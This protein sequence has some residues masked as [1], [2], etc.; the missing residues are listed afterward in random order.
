MLTHL[1]LKDFAIVDAV[2]LELG[3]GLTALTGETGAGKSI[4]VDAVMAVIG[5]RAGPDVVRHGSERA[6]ISATFDVTTNSD[7]QQWLADQSVEHDGEVN[8]RRVIGRDGR[9]RLYVN[10]QTLPLGVVRELGERLIDIH[11]QSEFLSLLRRDSQRALLD[12]FGATLEL[13]RPL[14]ALVA[15]WREVNARLAA[16]TAQAGDRAARLELLRYQ[17]QELDLV[18]TLRARL[19]PLGL[20]DADRE[21]ATRHA[22]PAHARG[23]R[24]AERLGRLVAGARQLLRRRLVLLEQRPGARLEFLHGGAGPVERGELG[25]QPLVHRRQL[26]GGHPMLAREFLHRGEPPFHLLLAARIDL[27][28]VEVVGQREARLLQPDQCLV[29]QGRGSGELGVVDHRRA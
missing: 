12:E 26:L 5:G 7:A 27:Q 21:A 8:L 18:A 14:A 9:S 17:V 15:D 4:L 13:V 11:G 24:L 16:L 28:A 10:G 23:H 22:E 29:E 6:E 3:A 2:E 20:G 25:A 19:E 1:Q